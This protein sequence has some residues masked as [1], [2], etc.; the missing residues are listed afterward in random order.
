MSGCIDQGWGD[1][2]DACAMRA[3]GKRCALTGQHDGVLVGDPVELAGMNDLLDGLRS[4]L[5][6]CLRLFRRPRTRGREP[7]NREGEVAC[8]GLDGRE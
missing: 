8:I 3:V 2:E 7:N 4:V 6:C 1:Q 5:R